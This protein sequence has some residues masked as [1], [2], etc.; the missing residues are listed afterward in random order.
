MSRWRAAAAAILTVLACGVAG[1]QQDFLNLTVPT[2]TTPP[3]PAVILL[4]G[5]SGIQENQ[6]MWQAFLASKG[7]ASASVDSLVRRHV[8]EICT[9][10]T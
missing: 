1:A 10:S 3:Y 5:C 8:T 2:G 6:P 9:D 4:H 7:Y